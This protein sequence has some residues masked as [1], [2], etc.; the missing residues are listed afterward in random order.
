MPF[1]ELFVAGILL[2]GL[3]ALMACGLNLVF[4]VMR[5]INFA[6]G[7]LLAVGA[8]TTVSLVAGMHL[9]YIAALVLAPLLTAALG[10][11]MQ[12]IVIRRI[13][14]GPMIMSLLATFALSTIIVNV[15]ILIWGGGYRGLPT[16]LGGS[17]AIAGMD[18]PLSRLVSFLVAMAATL[19]VWWFLQATRYGKAIRSVSQAPE[20]AVISGI[21]IN[22]VRN[23]TFALGAAMAGLAGV[24]LAPTF[25]SDAQL[26][27]RFGIKA[28]AVIIVGGMGSYPGAMLAALM[29]GVLEVF[30]GYFYGQV[31]G[32]AT[33]FLAMLIV[34]I[35]RPR[36]IF[37]M[38][39][40]A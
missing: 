5:V 20:L 39:A 21:S 9:P 40:R 2:G 28:F 4:G 19:G 17:V 23:V 33:V 11:A 14:D 12:W 26:G 7:D 29:M 27:A 31:L 36:G 34:L 22:Q 38:G 35:F 18:I 13:A 1:I 3:Y 8:L 6:H 32:A 10:L 25:A 30:A 15:A 16:V 24:L 37:G